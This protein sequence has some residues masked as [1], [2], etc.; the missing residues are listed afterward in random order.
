MRLRMAGSL[1]Y[2]INL[3]N[4]IIG[5]SVLAMPFCFHQVGIILG[6]ILLL[7]SATITE[8]SCTLLMRAAFASKRR[9]YEFLAQHTFGAAGKLAVEVCTIGMLIGSMIAFHVIIGDLGPNIISKAFSVPNTQTLRAFLLLVLACCVVAPL[10]LLRNIESLNNVSALSIGFYSVFVAQIFGS[11]FPQIWS[12]AWINKVNFW[13]PEGVFRCVPIFA[14][15]FGCQTQLFVMYDALP[16]PSLKQMNSIIRSAVGMCTSVYLAVGFFGYIAYCDA[17][18]ILGDILMHFKPT[19]ISEAIKFGFVLSVAVSFP[20]CIFPCRASIYTLLF[21]EQP[22]HH[23]ENIGGVVRIPEGKFRIITLA[24]IGLTLI[25]GIMVPKVEF[26]LGL[27]GSTM[28]SLICFIFPAIMFISV[29]SNS[30]ISK[31]S[32]QFVL[33]LG[34]TLL[35]ASTYTTLMSH[36]KSQQDP[37]QPNNNKP[38]NIPIQQPPITNPAD[39]V[40]N[41]PDLKQQNDL[42]LKNEVEK[43]AKPEEKPVAVDAGNEKRLEPVIPHPPD[44]SEKDQKP[45]EKLKDV[46]IDKQEPVTEAK[47][48][49]KAPPEAK[50]NEE[51]KKP[52]EEQQHELIKK[53]EKQQE[54]QKQLLVEQKQILKELKQHKEDHKE[55]EKIDPAAGNQ[56]AAAVNPVGGVNPAGVVNQAGGVNPAGVVNPAGGVNPAGAVNPRGVVNPAGAVNPAAAVNPAGVVNQAGA[57]NE[58]AVVN[59]AGAVNPAAAVNQAGGVNLG[60]VVKP[61][62]PVV[63][64]VVE[65]PVKK[66]I[67]EEVIKQDVAAHGDKQQQVTKVAIQ[68]NIQ[69]NQKLVEKMQAQEKIINEAQKILNN[70]INKIGDTNKNNI[71]APNIAGAAAEDGA[72]KI[73]GLKPVDLSNKDIN[74]NNVGDAAKHEPIQH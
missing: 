4:S 30:K 66:N 69:E 6:T 64:Q 61:A 16:D 41:K 8:I 68:K 54:E 29:M 14:L 49:L 60:G 2:I 73:H 45:N 13:R 50:K 63:Q 59:P 17:Q 31:S 51:E 32:A 19:I 67:A 26:I 52:L 27:T 23:H 11:A 55:N 5:V 1:P 20:L 15:A 34:V 39:I 48:G 33:F 65:N 22:A 62:N 12:G 36:D 28:G 70:D 47:L 37:V 53:L 72:G 21:A 38:D 57:V 18:V 43:I 9:S 74:N 46:V 35:L 40:R 25:I 44:E 56:A 10:G 3:G 58:E 7:G 71:A 24:I 42:Q